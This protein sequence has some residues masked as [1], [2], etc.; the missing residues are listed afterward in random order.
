MTTKNDI[1]FTYSMSNEA[2]LNNLGMQIKQMRLNKDIT[3]AQLG[4]MS[5]LSR[6]AIVEIEKTGMGSMNSFIQILRSLEKLEILNHFVTEAAISPIQIAK[7]HGK[8]RK[9]ASKVKKKPIK[10]Y[11]YE[12]PEPL[13]AAEPESPTW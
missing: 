6:T 1:K 5:G 12:E 10:Y 7:L 13:M 3:Q 9:R 8:I 2:I 4:N 11:K